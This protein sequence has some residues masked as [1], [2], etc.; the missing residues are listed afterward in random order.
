MVPS[1]ISIWVQTL[2]ELLQLY[3]NQPLS[4]HADRPIVYQLV[5]YCW[6]QPA[7][8]V[9]VIVLLCWAYIER[10]VSLLEAHKLS[11]IDLIVPACTSRVSHQHKEPF[12]FGYFYVFLLYFVLFASLFVFSYIPAHNIMGFDLRERRLFDLKK[13]VLSE[14]LFKGRIIVEFENVYKYFVAASACI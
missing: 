8:I 11:S 14:K 10:P 4:S 12:L 2:C 13:K 6:L 3:Y 5:L 9:V 1:S 7:R